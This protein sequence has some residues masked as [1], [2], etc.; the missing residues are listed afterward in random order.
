MLLFRRC[1][2]YWLRHPIANKANHRHTCTAGAKPLSEI[3]RMLLLWLWHPDLILG[4]H[5]THGKPD[6]RRGL[7]TRTSSHIR[8]VA[9]TDF[10]HAKHASGEPA[11]SNAARSGVRCLVLS[12]TRCCSTVWHPGF[13]IG[14]LRLGTYLPEN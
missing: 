1:S 12:K 3:G 13:E 11:R 4:W 10:S 2:A 6:A 7:H 8:T 9:P 5:P 14:D